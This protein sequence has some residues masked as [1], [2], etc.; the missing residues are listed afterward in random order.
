MDESNGLQRLIDLQTIDSR[1]DRLRDEIAAIPARLGELEAR[2]AESAQKL[3]RTQIW[4]ED[5]RK[6]RRAL[7]GDVATLRERLSR[8]K[9]QLMEVKTNREYQAMLHEISATE[10]EISR[11][12]DQILE[13]MLAADEQKAQLKEVEAQ[14]AEVDSQLSQQRREL[15]Q[16][17][18]TAEQE[19]EQLTDRRSEIENEIPEELKD[20]Y[21]RI[22]AARGNA[23]A[24]A[25]DQ[26][27]QNCHVRLRPQLFTEVK[28][29]RKIITCEN[30]NRILYF[31]T[32]STRETSE[33]PPAGAGDPVEAT[34]EG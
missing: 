23:L 1:V 22:A 12:E 5:Q 4:L 27:C 33:M 17:T 16:F 30:C 29:G 31:K 19:I 7:E 10:E 32:P 26:S 11:G 18:V 15:E 8:F 3:E 24:E 34:D 14:V 20:L 6:R 2:R 28:S 9:T 25:R 13:S 21:D